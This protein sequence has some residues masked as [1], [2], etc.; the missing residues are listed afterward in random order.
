[1]WAD[2]ATLAYRKMYRHSSSPPPHT[3]PPFLLSQALRMA[4]NGE[5]E[6]M[7]RGMRAAFRMLK[8]GGVIAVITWK[9]SEVWARGAGARWG[10][11]V[12]CACSSRVASLP[13]SRGSIQRC[14]FGGRGV[15]ERVG[16]WRGMLATLC[17][18]L[19]S[20]PNHPS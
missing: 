13:S 1:M 3:S 8:P 4:I 16:C 10:G 11:A 15:R 6:Q 12:Y 2:A 20:T 18:L 14:V 7:M 17:M 19:P 9:H 5:R